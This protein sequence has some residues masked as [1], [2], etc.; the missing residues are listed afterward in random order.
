MALYRQI[1]EKLLQP[2]MNARHTLTAA[3]SA[4]TLALVAGAA[5]PPMQEWPVYA[6]DAAATHYSPLADI[7]TSNVEELVKH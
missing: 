2:L 6:A 5:A 3:I 7:D 1:C 4:L